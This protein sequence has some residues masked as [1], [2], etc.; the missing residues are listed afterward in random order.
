MARQR[1][2]RHDIRC[3]DCGSNWMRKDGFNNGR[4]TY[5]CG[6][7]RRRYTPGGAYR[8]PGPAVKERGL[9]MYC[10]GASLS[11]IGRV[12]GYSAPAVLGWVKQGAPGAEPAAGAR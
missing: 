6:D 12:L 8:R 1:V 7:C 2:Y 4:Q 9:D 11:A 5:S 10:E 3:P